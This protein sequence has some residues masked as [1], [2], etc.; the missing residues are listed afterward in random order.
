MTRLGIDYKD[1][2]GGVRALNLSMRIVKPPSRMP[3]AAAAA[4]AAAAV[5]IAL[6]PGSASA[7]VI[8]FGSDLSAPASVAETHQADTSFW[9]PTVKDRSNALPADGQITKIRL[10]GTAVERSGGPAPENQIHFQVIRPQPDGSLTVILS[11]DPKYL[12]YTGD[13]NQINTFQ[14]D[15]YMCVK[16]GDFV[17]FND[18]GG[19][20]PNVYQDGV[21]FRVF[22]NVASSTTNQFTAN[23][24]T[25]IGANF[26]GSSKRGE[27]LLMQMQLR[28]GY[29]ASPVCPGGMKGKEFKG[30]QIVA[31]QRVV[32][33]KGIGRVRALCPGTSQGG[34][35]GT[36]T[37]SSKGKVLGAAPFSIPA[38]TTMNVKVP[39]R[40]SRLGRSG[41][42]KAT[43][44]AA[45]HD[46]L[47]RTLRTKGLLTLADARKLNRR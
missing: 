13:A 19:W 40:A 26:R 27:E 18:N 34:C 46:D 7:R 45:A 44:I 21:P 38:T 11:S 33:R 16:K 23:N 35:K 14:P 12:P 43:A 41:R 32:V 5:A 47:G 3:F 10:K 17:S 39:V 28:T 8:T 29:D 15:G 20:V 22:G 9:S 37:L 31:K 6:V 24:G 25:G 2:P 1:A 4:G 30:L 36:L 42:R